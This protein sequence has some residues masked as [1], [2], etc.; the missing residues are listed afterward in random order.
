[1]DPF[2]RSDDDSRSRGHSLQPQH[3]NADDN[4]DQFDNGETSGDTMLEGMRDFTV[5]GQRKDQNTIFLKLRIADSSGHIRNIHFP[6]DIEADTSNAVASEMVEELDLTDHDVSVIAAMIDSEIRYHIPDWA[7]RELSS[8]N[9]SNGDVIPE[10]GGS[11][12]HF[13]SPMTN[14]SAQT[15]HLVLERLPSGRKYWSDSP[16]AGGESSPLKPGPSN[17]M[18]TDSVASGDGWSEENSQSPSSHKDVDIHSDAST[19]TPCSRTRLLEEII[20]PSGTDSGDIKVIIEKLEHV[21]DEQ[22]KELDELKQK[23]EL[24]VSDLLKELPQEIRGTVLS[25]CN[26]KISGHRLP[27]DRGHL[28]NR[29]MEEGTS[30]V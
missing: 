6:F 30:L 19:H 21:L 29:T 5:Q 13:D 27:D 10:S 14:D 23:H 22:L 17:L 15:G 18:P 28:E 16:K 1:M 2:L 4:G 3:S 12:G 8:N 11:G 25:L 26:K 24:A 20:M 7:P 9:S